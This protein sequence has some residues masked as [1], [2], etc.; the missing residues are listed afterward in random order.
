MPTLVPATPTPS[1]LRTHLV[2]APVSAATV[3][4]VWASQLAFLLGRCLPHVASMRLH[5]IDPAVTKDTKIPLQWRPSP[6]C[7]LALVTVDLNESAIVKVV[8]R[9]LS[10]DRFALVSL[11]V[12]AGAGVIAVP[13]LGGLAPLDGSTALLQ[14][15]PFRVARNTHSALVHLGDAGDVADAIHDITVTISQSGS[16]SHSGAAHVSLIEL[17]VATLRPETGEVGLLLPSIDA[18]NDLHDGDSSNGSGITETLTAEQDAATR[19]REHFQIATYED[20]AYAWTRS[21]S[22][23]G[24]INWVGSVG[25]SV[26]PKFRLRVP[27]VYGTSASTPATFT[28]RVRYRSTKD[29]TLRVVRTTVGGGAT[30]NN[31]L[32]LPGS[33]GAWTTASGTLTLRADGTDQE[34]DLQFN[35]STADASTLYIS[36]IAIIQ[37]ETP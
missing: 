1:E 11:T 13:E 37:T 20:T 8:G 4:R 5:A 15:D 17:P 2:A 31:D 14:Q 12:P 25:T 27:A 23:T 9:S 19:V 22:T 33:G 35:A 24:A 16:Y 34:I 6:G 3:G 21:S 29:G 7:R 30:S 28:L 18:R 10:G 32:A 26:D 36:S